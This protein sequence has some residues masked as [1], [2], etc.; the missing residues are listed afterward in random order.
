[1]EEIKHLKSRQPLGRLQRKIL[2][3]MIHTPGEIPMKM[4]IRYIADQIYGKNQHTPVNRK[5]MIRAL[6][7]LR[8]RR[9]TDYV[10]EQAATHVIGQWW[11]TA[12]GRDLNVA[13]VVAYWKEEDPEWFDEVVLRLPAE[14]FFKNQESEREAIE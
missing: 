6:K 11:L 13:G 2:F 10:Y 1:M 14:G 8:N 4:P 7:S 5:V 9:L 3:V 12:K